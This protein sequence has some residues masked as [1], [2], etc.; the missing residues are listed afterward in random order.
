MKMHF[1]YTAL[2][3]VIVSPLVALFAYGVTETIIAAVMFV[4]RSC[5]QL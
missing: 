5:A 4:V 2:M 1:R 3:F